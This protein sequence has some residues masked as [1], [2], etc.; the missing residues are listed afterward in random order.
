MKKEYFSQEF[1]KFRKT[2]R[3]NEATDELEETGL[4]DIVEEVNSYKDYG[5][6]SQLERFLP[7][8]SLEQREQTELQSRLDFMQEA[9]RLGEQYR[10]KFGLSED[11]PLEDVFKA[12][13]GRFDA[14][15]EV[16]AKVP[17]DNAETVVKTDFN[18]SQGEGVK[19]EEVQETVNAEK[20]G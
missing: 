8:E 4:V 2:Y 3:L 10:E 6:E 16:L 13:Q 5:L 7:P 19:N 18:A 17:Q 1:D 20:Q 15:S 14:L 9:F 11:T 12:V